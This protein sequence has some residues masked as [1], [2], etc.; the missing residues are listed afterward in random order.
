MNCIICHKTTQIV[1][2][3]GDYPVYECSNCNHRFT[4]PKDIESH[5]CKT[6]S[7]DYFFC[8]GA[9]YPNYLDER[10]LLLKR[11]NW[12]GKL[13]GKHIKRPGKLL[14][15]GCAAGFVL[16]GLVDCGWEG[17]GIEPN[18][19]MAEYARNNLKLDVHT[20]TIESYSLERKFDLICLIQVVAHIVDLGQVV[21]R[22]KEMLSNEGVILIETWNCRSW[23]AR[24]FGKQ[25]HEYSPPSVLHWF[26]PESLNQLFG[27]FNFEIVDRG[28]P[29]KKITWKHA[30]SIISYKLNRLSFF[31]Q[32]DKIFRTIPEDFTI[33]YPAEDLFWSLYKKQAVA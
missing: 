16:K 33:P 24:L 23:T 2:K 19:C 21:Q 4:E 1:F 28:R 29:P 18:E 13:V 6:Y 22:L 7:D 26:C 5:V 25:W 17:Y 9:G 27:S 12:Y 31:S 8:G 14:D 20:G 3:I 11:G 32:I 15:I 30:A 10:D